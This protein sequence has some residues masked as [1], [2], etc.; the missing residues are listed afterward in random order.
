MNDQQKNNE[1]TNNDPQTLHRKITK[2]Q[3]MVHKQ[4]TENVRKVTLYD[5]G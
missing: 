3:T 2:G 4:Y 1:R 5:P